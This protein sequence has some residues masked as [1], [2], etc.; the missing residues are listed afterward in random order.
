M[1][2]TAAIAGV[3]SSAFLA[4]QLLRRGVATGTTRAQ[5]LHGS[6]GSAGAVI[7]LA[8]RCLNDTGIVPNLLE[9]YSSI[10]ESMLHFHQMCHIL[11]TLIGQYSPLLWHRC[12]D[13][14]Q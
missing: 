9:Y 10:Q 3:L 2:W 4:R 5:R 14:K 7:G 8:S 12:W 11:H 6:E 13:V 1:F